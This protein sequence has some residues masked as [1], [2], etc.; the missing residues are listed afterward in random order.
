MGPTDPILSK[1]KKM[2]LQNF[3]QLAFLKSFIFPI[4]SKNKKMILQNF[5]RLAFFK[6]FLSAF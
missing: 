2:I 4:F 3:D 1:N 6:S 5:D